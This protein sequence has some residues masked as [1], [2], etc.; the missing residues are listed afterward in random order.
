MQP[1]CLLCLYSIGYTINTALLTGVVGTIGY[2]D[3]VYLDMGILTKE[4]DI[5]SFGVVLMEVLSGK[6][7]FQKNIN[8]TYSTLVQTWKKICKT[9]RLDEIVFQDVIQPLHPDSLETF[10]R[11]ALKC[12][13]KCRE[14][15][16]LM[17]HVVKELEA[18]LELQEPHD[19]KLPKEYEDIKY[20][21]IQDSEKPRF[22]NT[23]S[24]INIQG[25]LTS[26]YKSFTF[27]EIERATNGFSDKKLLGEGVLGKVFRGDI[28]GSRYDG[29]VAVK[30]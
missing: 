15:R 12:L 13:D 10:S 25:S 17:Y 8:G 16:P 21:S 9:G 1:L 23:Y 6:L 27:E 3:P 4:S 14:N 11:I 30:R 26:S 28:S 20:E 24:G 19:L 18:T 2:L 5:Y 29:L 22:Q 7:C